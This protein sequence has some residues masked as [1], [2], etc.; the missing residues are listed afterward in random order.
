[1]GVFLYG[2]YFYLLIYLF[3]YSIIC[4]EKL[5]IA[6]KQKSFEIKEKYVYMFMISFIVINLVI[7]ESKYFLFV[8]SQVGFGGLVII[9]IV[10]IVFS[11]FILYMLRDLLE[12]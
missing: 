9:V 10:Y 5:F 11:F 2:F 4:D 1:M 7:L 8:N 6:K 3:V 12:V